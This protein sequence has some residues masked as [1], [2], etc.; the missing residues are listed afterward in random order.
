MGRIHFVGIGG[1]GMSALARILLSRG[2]RVSGS[3]LKENQFTRELVS[4]GVPVYYGH[5]PENIPQ[6]TVQ[7]VVSSAISPDNPEVQEAHGRGIPVVRRGELLA[8]LFNSRQ[9]VAV[10]GAHGKTTTTALIAWILKEA[11]WNPEA[12][13]GGHVPQFGGNVLTGSGPHFVAEADESDGSFLWLKPS[14]A[15]ITNVEGDHL[16]YYK[17]QEG[18]QAAFQRFLEGL[19]SRAKAVLCHEDPWLR[20]MAERHRDRAITYGWD[21]ALYRAREVEL[22]GF[23]SRAKVYF[24]TTP[25]GEINLKIP[26]YHNVLNALGALA[27]AQELGVPFP[28]AA[29]AIASFTGVGRRFQVLWNKG[30]VVVDDYAHHPTEITATLKAA[31]LM[32]ANR[33]IA[34]FQPHRYTRTKHFY[35]E[36]ASS[37]MAAPV[38]VITDIYPAGEPP[39]DGVGAQLIVQ[40]MKRLN[41]PCVH[42]IHCLEDIVEF[43]KGSWQKGDLILTLGA[44][45]VSRVAQDLACY[46]QSR[47]KAEDK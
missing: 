10:A 44:G 13:V 39:L 14:I 2:F 19:P 5:R 29:E 12:A 43:L 46:L 40:E 35:R 27:A 28:V 11:G 30:P 18:L 42:H 24:K 20:E 34:V 41:H 23:T 6:D 21:S 1:V 37:L 26:G 33:I 25:L 36:F 9:G 15:V 4:L 31:S 47:E 8:R 32:G 3:D 17:N 38:V 7:L 16:E 45:D 22:R